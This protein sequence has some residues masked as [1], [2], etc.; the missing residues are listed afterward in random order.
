MPPDIDGNRLKD[1]SSGR[2]PVAVREPLSVIDAPVPFLPEAIEEGPVQF[3]LR[4]A[5]AGAQAKRT[6]TR[7]LRQGQKT[8]STT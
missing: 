4:M 7:I 3:Q 8:I 2:P 1:A 5:L 6:L